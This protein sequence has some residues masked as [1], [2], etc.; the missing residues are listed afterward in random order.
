MIGLTSS[1]V[2]GVEPKV[3]PTGNSSSEFDVF[4]LSRYAYAP[5]DVRACV[6]ATS[7]ARQIN[8]GRS[9]QGS[10][11]QAEARAIWAD[12]PPHLR[13]HASCVPRI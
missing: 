3:P 12:Y 5:R 1:E 10:E 11:N 13:V 4:A 2:G 6:R 7:R 8:R 9:V